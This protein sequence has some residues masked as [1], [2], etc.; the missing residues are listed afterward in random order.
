MMKT[1]AIDIKH[2]VFNDETE[3]TLYITKDIYSDSFIVSVPVITFSYQIRE[4]R[5]G[6][7]YNELL[8]SNRIPLGDPV[9]KERLVE[10]I[11]EAIAEFEG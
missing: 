8:K 10:V 4:D 6:R 7:D 3:A 2:S 1:I 11:K 9:Q 5:A